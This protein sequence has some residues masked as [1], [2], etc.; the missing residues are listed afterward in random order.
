MKIGGIR[1]GRDQKHHDRSVFAPF[2][3]ALFNPFVQ[4]PAIGRIA[5]YPVAPPVLGQ[6][7][8]RFREILFALVVFIVGARVKREVKFSVQAVKKIPAAWPILPLRC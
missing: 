8:F 4:H 5:K 1:A 7:V 2:P 6:P 3:V